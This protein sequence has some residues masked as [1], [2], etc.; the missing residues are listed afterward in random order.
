MGT[1]LLCVLSLLPLLCVPC[2]WF[3]LN[4][5]D[6]IEYSK[7]QLTQC[8]YHNTA[9]RQEV[10]YFSLHRYQG[11]SSIHLLQVK[12]EHKQLRIPQQIS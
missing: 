5:S 7:Q 2:P 3:T 6:L 11:L 12:S 4:D 8:V 1:G 10:S 9:L